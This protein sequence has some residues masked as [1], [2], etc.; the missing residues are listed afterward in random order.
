MTL[1]KKILPLT[2]A[3]ALILPGTALAAPKSKFRFSQA[4]YVA[5]EGQGT[6][7][8]TV[9]RIPRHGHSKINQTSSVN[10]AVTGGS[11]T[12]GTDYTLNPAPGK[13]TFTSG[14]TTK[15]VTVN[16]NQDTDIEG[17]E[18]IGLKLSAASNNALIS[19]PRT[20]QVM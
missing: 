6:L 15:S 8:I 11:A 12:Q 4:T 1:T 19:Q 18:S 5:S 2:A 16:L 9:T 14:Q 20:A 7:D 10:F 17:V 3:L 13:L